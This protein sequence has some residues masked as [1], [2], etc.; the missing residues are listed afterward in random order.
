MEGFY[1]FAIPLPPKQIQLDFV[2]SFRSW[3]STIWQAVGKIE[4]SIALLR[5]YRAALITA[6]VTGQI[7]VATWGRDGRTER[8]LDQIEEATQP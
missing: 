1:N 2:A 8:R 3:R 6:A 4:Q 5:E 7:D